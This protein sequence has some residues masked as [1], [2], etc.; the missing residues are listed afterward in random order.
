MKLRL[1]ALTASLILL[2]SP[3]L[4]FAS[5]NFSIR[6]GEPIPSALRAHVEGK[7][8]LFLLVGPKST[9]SHDALRQA[10][11][12]VWQPLKERGFKV[13]GICAGSKSDAK[14]LSRNLGLTFPVVA[15]PD[16]KLY[17]LLATQGVPR[18]IIVDANGR[19]VDLGEGWTPGTEAKWRAVGEELVAGRI[20]MPTIGSD[21]SNELGARDIRGTK[22]PDVPVVEWVN[23]A[24]S[25]LKGQYVLYDFWATWCGPCIQSL[26]EAEEFHGEFDGRLVTIAVSNEDFETVS[27]FVKKKGWKQPIGVDPD[28]TMMEALEIRGIPHAFLKDPDGTVIWQG[29]PSLLWQNNAKELKFHLGLTGK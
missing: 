14:D 6:G 25:D 22:A 23:E 19:I 29:H 5:G 3:G 28:G 8:T 7:G 15:D 2:A 20:V 21:Y 18:S 16:R 27:G 24:P 9:K 12:Y 1:R 10:E 4:L 11:S 26:G 17:D 13:V